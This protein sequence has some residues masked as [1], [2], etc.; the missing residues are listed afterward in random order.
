MSNKIIL[1]SNTIEGRAIAY[2]EKSK[3]LHLPDGTEFVEVLM[4]GSVINDL[5][6]DS[7]IRLLV[8]H[9]DS[10]LLGRN[11]KNL[12]LEERE[13]GIYFKC[14]L[15]NTTLAKDTIENIK[16]EILTSMSFDFELVNEESQNITYDEEGRLLR[17][18]NSFK[19]IEISCVGNPA[20]SSTS[21]NTRAYKQL[22]E[23]V[24]FKK[25]KEQEEMKSDNK[26][27]TIIEEMMK[28][29]SNLETL[30]QEY[31]Q[32]EPKEEKEDKKEEE[33][34]EETVAKEEQTEEETETKEEETKVEDKE[35]NKEDMGENPSEKSQTK[36][37]KEVEE[38]KKEADDTETKETETTTEK[39]K[40]EKEE[41]STS[42]TKEEEE[43]EK[44]KKEKL[45]NNTKGARSNMR[46]QK[47]ILKGKEETKYTEAVNVL[48]KLS[49]IEE[50]KQ[51]K[52]INIRALSNYMHETRSVTRT[53]NPLLV[54]E[55]VEINP[56]RTFHY[57]VVLRELV[58][59]FPK[60]DTNTIGRQI[61][62]MST[63]EMIPEVSD[64]DVTP[65]VDIVKHFKIDY[66]IKTRRGK[67]SISNEM[68]L[69]KTSGELVK[70]VLEEFYRSKT[71]TDNKLIMSQLATKTK[72]EIPA[73]SDILDVIKIKATSHTINKGNTVIL[74]TES[75]Y[76]K[77]HTSKDLTGAYRMTP[78]MKL[79]NHFL[80]YGIP[81]L[82]IP[83]KYITA[84]VDGSTDKAFIYS[85]QDSI[86]LFERTEE[87][88]TYAD[89][90]RYGLSCQLAYGIDVRVIDL[91]TIEHLEF[92][93]PV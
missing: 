65:D 28:I 14:T 75:L 38:L 16:N 92:K 33:T 19:L 47:D 36:E 46:V 91:T 40:E 52:G 35:E 37:T 90:E 62:P 93:K 59:T 22:Q 45:K 53:T 70:D 57:D 4:Q 15:A 11:T 2:G 23:N 79:P 13:D 66:D 51:S 85:T 7:D 17:Q 74:V 63:N 41:T 49:N 81:M 80:F 29:K 69:Q 48:N 89:N 9:D 71:V 21:L 42:L 84:G 18:I 78:D 60:H 55:D 5:N 68:L 72:E 54:V 24:D 34:K 87:T 82:V 6:N 3:V 64:L 86:A 58:R 83:D 27:K 88:I 44:N 32:E 30:L 39:P 25:K 76:S 1:K 56:Y 10:K 61:I 12:T 43:E 73:T 50:A 77:I 67:V 20:Y 8:E 26:E 31:N